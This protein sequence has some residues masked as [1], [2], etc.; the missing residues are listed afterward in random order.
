MIEAFTVTLPSGIELRC[1]ATG[2]VDAPLLLFLHGFPEGAFIWDQVMSAL[3]PRYRC[4]APDLRGY[5]ESSAPADVDAYRVQILVG[6][7]DAL[8]QHL[9]A[10]VAALV[11]HDWGGALAWALGAQGPAWLQRLLIINSPHP[12]TFLRELQHSAAQQQASAYMN[13]LCRPDAEELLAANDFERMWPF[14]TAMGARDG[15]QPG[16]GWL[17]EEVRDDYRQQ[18]KHGL[19]GALNYY[20][21]SPIRPPTAGNQQVRS[22]QLPPELTRVS[23]PTLVLWAEADTALPPALLDGLESHVPDLRVVRIP[24]ATHWVIHEQP[25]RVVAE[26]GNFVA[27][28]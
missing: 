13:F 1:R 10:P 22:L 19:R 8:V 18:W 2:D 15:S 27:T 20:R 24:K 4:V 5:G 14:F 16:G 17:T 11:A 28:A 26:I 21:A 23:V 9:H 12:A 6:D 7:I 25:Q 3:A